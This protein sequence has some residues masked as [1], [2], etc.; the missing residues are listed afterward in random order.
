MC[1]Q[2]SSYLPPSG[3]D[4]TNTGES[5]AD[6][7]GRADNAMSNQQNI[8]DVLQ[9]LMTITDQSLDEAQA[10]LVVNSDVLVRLLVP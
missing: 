10:R 6:M 1:F 4:A 9:Q 2:Q 8:S 5:A 3:Y 7:S